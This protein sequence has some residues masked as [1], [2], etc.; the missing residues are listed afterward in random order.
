MEQGIGGQ[1]DQALLVDLQAHA[2]GFTCKNSALDR[3]GD[4]SCGNRAQLGPCSCSACCTCAGQRRWQAHAGHGG[5]RGASSC[6]GAA[7]G[8]VCL[9][10]VHRW[11]CLWLA[12]DQL[13]SIVCGR[14]RLNLLRQAGLAKP[15]TCSKQPN[16]SLLVHINPP[17]CQKASSTERQCL[18][19]AGPSSWR[20]QLLDSG[21][22]D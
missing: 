13:G 5:A 9:T 20:P 6:S 1:C 15:K 3:T 7:D 4:W 21:L 19:G 22:Q 11:G 16:Q 10:Q 8:R 17:M 2:H 18:A 14:K 12:T